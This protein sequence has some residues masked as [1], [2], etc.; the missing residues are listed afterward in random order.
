MT[1]TATITCSP[2]SEDCGRHSMATLVVSNDSTVVYIV[3]VRPFASSYYTPTDFNIPWL[4]E[5]PKVTGARVPASGEFSCS[6]DF[7]VEH[8]AQQYLA[9]G[10]EVMTSDGAS[11]IATTPF[12]VLNNDAN[13]PKLLGD[14]L[15][16]L[17]ENSGRAALL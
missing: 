4:F 16:N 5:R 3:D 10:A 9:I 14:M 1:I 15:F 8:S 13:A 11:T 7:V 12:L 6:W 2:E 17:F